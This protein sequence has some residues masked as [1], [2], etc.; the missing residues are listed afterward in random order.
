MNRA[1]SSIDDLLAQQRA[2]QRRPAQW[3]GQQVAQIDHQRAAIGA[4]QAARLD[5]PEIGHQRALHREMLDAAD[6]VAQRRM[7]LLDHR[8]AG[9]AIAVVTST[10]TS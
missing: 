1:T 8:R 4:M 3:L 9:L 5:Q 6:Q 10:F 7:H 2:F